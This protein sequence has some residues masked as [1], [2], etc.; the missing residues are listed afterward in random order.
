M[1]NSPASRSPPTRAGRRQPRRD[2]FGRTLGKG[3]PPDEWP[4][5]LTQTSFAPPEIPRASIRSFLTVTDFGARRSQRLRSPASPSES[6]PSTRDTRLPS[7][8][9]L[10]PQRPHPHKDR[11]EGAREDRTTEVDDVEMDVVQGGRRQH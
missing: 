8:P 10:Q 11:P 3:E 2:R 7:N 1:R 4:A 5:A 9:A 6:A